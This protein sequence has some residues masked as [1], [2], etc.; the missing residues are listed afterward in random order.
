MSFTIGSNLQWIDARKKSRDLQIEMNRLLK[1][2][3]A[4]RQKS[5][6]SVK[7]IAEMLGISEACMLNIQLDRHVVSID[8]AMVALASLGYEISVKL[9]Y[10]DTQNG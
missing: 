7:D 5:G 8:G 10:K 9:T 6:L 2:R 4:E 3:I 1:V